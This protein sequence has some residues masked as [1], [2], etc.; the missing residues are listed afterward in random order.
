MKVLLLAGEGAIQQ[1]RLGYANAMGH[2]G[3]QCL[4]WHPGSNRP[5]FDV[6][7]E[8]EPDIVFCGSWEIDEAMFKNLLRRPHIKVILWGGNWGD[9]DS[10]INWKA[11]PI[12][13]ISDREK[14]ILSILAKN[15]NIKHVFTYYHQ[16]WADVTHNFWN[17]LGLQPIGVPLAADLVTYGLAQSTP[18]LSC[19]ISFVGGYWPY[20]A[21]NLNQYL[22]PL[23]HPEEKLKIK[24][25]GYGAW[26]VV[27]YLGTI[28]NDNIPLLF[29]SST[30]N[31]N[32]FEPLSSK[33]GFDVNERCYKILACGGFCISEYC[34]SAANDIFNNN[35]IVFAKNPT[36]FKEQAKYYIAHPE[37][38]ESYK[39]RGISAIKYSHN[40]FI[41]LKTIFQ[42]ISIS[43]AK[44]DKVITGLQQ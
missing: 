7:D 18:E 35:E 27:Q 1:V 41:R 19:D 14:S 11:D 22:I 43:T 13:R 21:I 4:I 24:I 42:H 38:R 20:K 17:N 32:I 6:F 16:K 33:Y 5:L 40:Y 30:V 23:C 34:E 36:E 26:P 3:H 29:A 44:L 39:Q 12:L 15:N 10:Q 31:A 28:S 9:F 37:E 2:I 8:F 25:F